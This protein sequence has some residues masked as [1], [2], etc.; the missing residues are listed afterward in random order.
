MLT[1]NASRSSH[2][3]YKCV[4]PLTS[5]HNRLLPLPV[6]LWP[7]GTLQTRL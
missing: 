7:Y 6:Q 4:D 5:T 2:I 1:Q 3:F